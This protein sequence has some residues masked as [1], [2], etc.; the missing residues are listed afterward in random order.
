MN[1]LTSR[2]ISTFT[3]VERNLKSITK[4]DNFATFAV[5]IDK[6]A[7]RSAVVRTMKGT[8]KDFADLRNVLVHRYDREKEIAIP[9]EEAVV[10]LEG[11]LASLTSPRKLASL[12][13]GPVEV[14]Q[15][16]EPV[17]WTAK[18]MRA[19]SFSQLPVIAGQRIAGLLTSD[20]IARWLATRL[21]GG[22]GMLEEEPVEKVLPHQEKTRVH[23]LMDR[24]ATVY[25]ALETFDKSF[26][27]GESLDAII[28]TNSGRA[29]DAPLRIVTVFDMPQLVR[30]ARG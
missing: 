21:D 1:T 11:I 26:R 15:L 2:F 30:E 24:S 12:F 6:A 25:D 3:K 23:V 10:H 29:T 17:G 13:R 9:S 5:L 18:K 19:G 4:K 14:C 28:L 8:L 27:A 16:D 22:I 20:T 7:E